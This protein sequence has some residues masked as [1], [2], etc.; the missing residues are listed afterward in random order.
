MLHE[1][2]TVHHVKLIDHCQM[3]AAARG[4]PRLPRDEMRYGVPLFLAHV[5]DTLRSE[6]DLGSTDDQS[7]SRFSP[8]RKATGNTSIQ[9]RNRART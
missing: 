8:Y 4:P 2:L 5:I 1:F 3:L 9:N 7:G 6:L